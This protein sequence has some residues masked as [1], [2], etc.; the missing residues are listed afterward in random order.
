ML[1]RTG[2]GT[3][4]LE[5]PERSKVVHFTSYL[6]YF[7]QEVDLKGSATFECPLH[8]LRGVFYLPPSGVSDLDHQ[9]LGKK[10]DPLRIKQCQLL[11]MIFVVF[12]LF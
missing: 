1:L 11:V 9:R 7:W 5:W 4:S 10:S 3:A 6:V 2:C 8:P 12:M